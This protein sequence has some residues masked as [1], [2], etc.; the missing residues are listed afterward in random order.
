MASAEKRGTGPRP[1]RARYKKPDGTWG[2]EPGFATKSAALKWGNDQESDIRHG[3]WRD[4]RGGQITLDAWFGL[5]L[6][7]QNYARRTRER[8]EGDFRNHLRP[9]W[10]DRA[11]GEIG[12]LDVAAFENR[13]GACLAR[14]TIAGIMSLLRMLMEDAVADGR[15]TMSP[16]VAKRRRGRRKDVVGKPPR[17]ATALTLEAFMAIALR[18]PR[19]NSLGAVAAVMAVVTA[20]TGM[21]WGE[22]SAMQRK[23]LMLLPAEGGMPASGWYI[24]DDDEGAVHDPKRGPAYLGPPKGYV[25][26][27]IE[28]PPFLV[29]LLLIYTASLPPDQ[30][31]LFVTSRG[32]MLRSRCTVSEAWRLACDGWPA[33]ESGYGRRAR[34][35]A[36]A[37]VKGLH[38]HDLRHTHKTWLA[39]DGVPAVARD[40]RLGHRR[41]NRGGGADSGQQD[42]VY[43]HATAVMRKRVLEGLQRRWEAA[44]PESAVLRESISRFFP[45]AGAGAPQHQVADG[46]GADRG[47]PLGG[48]P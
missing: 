13:L 5:W 3:R 45:I 35:E 42:H 18:L 16:V 39:E 24:V 23:F 34:V 33:R 1:W 21:R 31:L 6:P 38:W 4:P 26:R 22:V 17:K 27:T 29:E 19:V 28:L 14:N 32:G 7:A 2:S 15:L 46:A 11:I 20:F 37:V 9:W 36:A 41:G 10:G 12:L 30:E 25:G 43:V 47:Q 40:E 44:G 8:L 48:W